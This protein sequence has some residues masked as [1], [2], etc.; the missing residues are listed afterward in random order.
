MPGF[1]N[2]IFSFQDDG[3]PLQPS[4]QA[5]NSQEQDID[6]EEQ[7]TIKRLEESRKLIQALKVLFG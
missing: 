3:A 1:V 2:A 7:Q 6:P 5:A 4:S